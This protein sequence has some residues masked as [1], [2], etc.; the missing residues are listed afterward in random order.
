MPA[1]KQFDATVRT[2]FEEFAGFQT[3][4]DQWARATLAVNGGG[5]GLRSVPTTQLPPTLLPAPRATGFAKSW[6]QIMFGRS[7]IPPRQ[8]QRR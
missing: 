3:S 5:L 2:C 1:L 7:R 8:L 6:T 4:D